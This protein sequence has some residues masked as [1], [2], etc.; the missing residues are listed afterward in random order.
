[1]TMKLAATGKITVG[2]DLGDRYSELHVMNGSG[3]TE[4]VGRVRT[5][6]AS[7]SRRF[8]S[9]VPVRVVMEVGTH[10]PWVSR[11]LGS[12]GHEVIVASAGRVRE[13]IGDVDKTDPIDARMLARLGQ[14][15]P[16]LLRA[17]A[18]R[19]LEAQQDLAVIRARDALVRARSLLVNHVRSVVKSM[20]GRIGA[21]STPSLA[22]QA[23]R[24]LPPGVEPALGGVLGTLEQMTAAIREHDRQIEVLCTERY[25]VTSLLRQIKG[26]GPV[27]ALCYVL[28]IDDPFRFRK[29]RAVGAYLGLRPRRRASGA[30]DPELRITKQGDALLRRLLVQSAHY[31]LGPFGP[32]TDLRRWGLG[33][34]SGSKRAKKRAVVA[35][36]R[37]LSVLLHHLWVTAEV[38][39][40]LRDLDAS[41][42]DQAA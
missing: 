24:A 12:L 11:L 6:T 3:E 18:H 4:E 5:T 1:M 32:D 29:S 40:P 27:T 39:T 37:K 33:L 8:G 34:A 38:Y 9:G 17:I 23:R 14:V 36:A 30:R 20:G 16:D 42:H 21:C 13:M 26:V 25:P 19:G 2:L 22:K 31:I 41:V 7:L 15:A 28:T 10:S 35:V